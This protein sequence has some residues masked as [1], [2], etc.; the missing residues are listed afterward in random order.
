MDY[1]LKVLAALHPLL[2][3]REDLGTKQRRSTRTCAACYRQAQFIV[4]GSDH[5]GER[6]SCDLH[7]LITTGPATQR[8]TTK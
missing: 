1:L 4:A 7:A 6:G 5:G 3:R 8:S 2:R